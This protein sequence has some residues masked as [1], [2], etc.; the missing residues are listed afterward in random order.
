M[1]TKST[2]FIITRLFSY[3]TLYLNKPIGEI[4]LDEL[5]KLWDES[6]EN[7]D[8]MGSTEKKKTD[9]IKKL[10]S[11]SSTN[12]FKGD[13]PV[14]MGLFYGNAY[15]EEASLSNISSKGPSENEF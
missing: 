14:N 7:D 9:E 1:L 6:W 3:I 10:P 8:A 13:E 2:F 4:E 12:V 5:E 15:E 11:T